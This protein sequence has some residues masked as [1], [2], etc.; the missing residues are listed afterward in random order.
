MR[1]EDPAVLFRLSMVSKSIRTAA[2]SDEVWSAAITNIIGVRMLGQ[3]HKCMRGDVGDPPTNQIYRLMCGDTSVDVDP[4]GHDWQGSNRRAFIRLIRAL[5]DEF[6]QHPDSVCEMLT[7]ETEDEEQAGII[8]AAFIFWLSSK[9]RGLPDIRTQAI[10]ASIRSP[11]QFPPNFR[12]D[13]FSST[14]PH[15]PDIPHSQRS[16]AKHHKASC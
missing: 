4:A 13:S 6:V 15:A 16:V 5:A 2:E 11:V 7:G 8:M 1:I 9:R 3:L 12:I 14:D 10:K